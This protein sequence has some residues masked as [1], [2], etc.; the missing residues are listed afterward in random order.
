MSTSRGFSMFD[1]LDGMYPTDIAA[2]IIKEMLDDENTAVGISNKAAR[3][4]RMRRKKE[5]SNFENDV[6]YLVKAVTGFKES[7]RQL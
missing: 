1:E 4:E 2:E 5:M 6:N 3:E 7:H